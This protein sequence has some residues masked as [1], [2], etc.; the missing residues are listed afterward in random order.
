LKSFGYRKGIRITVLLYD[1]TYRSMA[2]TIGWLPCGLDAESLIDAAPI[3]STSVV[4]L[5]FGQ[6]TDAFIAG[7][8]PGNTDSVVLRGYVKTHI[9]APKPRGIMT[10]PSALQTSLA[11][12]GSH[13]WR[14]P[15]VSEA[16]VTP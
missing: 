13:I 4:K 10:P 6:L 3:G 7:G 5:P 15:V 2:H 8:L 11:S 16:V 14:E 9:V 1:G 12:N